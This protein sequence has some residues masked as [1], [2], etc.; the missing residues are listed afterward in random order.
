MNDEQNN[1]ATANICP[2]CKK[3]PCICASKN[4]DSQSKENKPRTKPPEI[5]WI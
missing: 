5:S 4:D 3:D 2:E 1:E